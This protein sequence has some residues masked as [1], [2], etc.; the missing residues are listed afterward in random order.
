VCDD[1]Y[2][3]ADQKVKYNS[4][5]DRQSD[6]RVAGSQ[7]V[8]K[9]VDIA[10]TV[11]SPGQTDPLPLTSAQSQATLTDQRRVTLR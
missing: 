9:Q 1:Q 10:V 7:R 3:L 2:R 4:S 11:D 5:E 6:V 8:I